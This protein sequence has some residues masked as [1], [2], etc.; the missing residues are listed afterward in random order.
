[1]PISTGPSAPAMVEKAHGPVFVWDEP[2]DDQEYII[3]AD[4][5]EGIPGRDYSVAYV[6]NRNRLEI[7]AM[8]RGRLDPEDFADLLYSLG[9]WYNWCWLAVENNVSPDVARR[10][11]YT[12]NYPK[13]W[14][15]KD[16]A[17][18]QKT[19]TRPGWTTNKRTRRLM[20]DL[21]QSYSKPQKLVVWDSGLPEEMVDF[22][23]NERL[24]RYEAAG[25]KHD[26]RLMALGVALG[27]L[28]ALGGC[29]TPE[30]PE[31][32]NLTPDQKYARLK[33][34]IKWS[35]RVTSRVQGE[36]PRGITLG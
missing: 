4:V 7:P 20:L 8:I 15:N 18:N 27:V 21:L 1:M 29:K 36:R 23:L 16:I 12:L 33:A 22:V 13:T 26:D 30:R 6:V 35:D 9:S 11:A 19:V 34:F 5:S 28:E 10:L 32:K 25:G 14:F 3:G 24:N 2:H 17:G 31:E